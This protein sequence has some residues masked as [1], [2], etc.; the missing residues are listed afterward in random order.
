MAGA[1]RRRHER[2]RPDRRIGRRPAGDHLRR[3][4]PCRSRWP[5]RPARSG[6]R[7]VLFALRG[8]ADPA[9]RRAP[10]RITG[11]RSA[12]SAAFCRHA[13]AEGCRDVVF[14][15]SVVRPPSAR[16][17]LDLARCGCCRSSSRR[18]AAAT[19]IC[20]RASRKHVRAAGLPPARRARGGAGN[21]DAA[22]RSVGSRRPSEATGR[23]RA[24]ACAAARHR[25]ASTSARRSSSPTTTCWRSRRRRAPT[26]CWSG[27]PS[28]A[29]R[30]ASTPGRCGVLV[31]APKP[32]Q[33]RRFDLPS[34]GP[35]TVEGAAPRGPRRH[36]GRRPA[37]PSSRSRTA[38][39]R[40]PTAPTYSSSASAPMSRPHDT[41][42]GPSAKP[43]PKIFLV[44]GRGIRRPAGRRA[45]A[46]A[47]AARWGRASILRRRRPRDGGRRA[48][49]PAFRLDDF[50][51]IGFSAIPR[52][53]P[54]ILIGTCAQTLRA[55]RERG[56]A[57]VAG[58]H[59]Q[60]GLHAR[61]ARCVR[62]PI[63]D[64]PI[65]DYVSPSV[66]AWRPGARASRCA[67][68]IDQ[69][70]RCCRSSP[71]CIAS[72]AGRRAA[73]SAIRSSSRSGSFGPTPTRRG[74]AGR[75]AG[76]AG[77]AG[78]PQ[79][80]DRE[81]GRDR[82]AKRSAGSASGS[83]RSRWWCRPCRICSI[84][85]PRRP[86]PGRSSRASSP[87]RPRSRRRSASRAR[88]SPSRHGH[89]GAR[90]RRRADG[91]GLQ[92]VGARSHR[93][94]PRDHACRRH[95][96][97]SGDRRERRAR[98]AAGGLHAGKACRRTRRCAWATRPERRRQIEAFAWLDA[99]MEIGARAPPRRARPTSCSAKSTAPKQRGARRA[100]LC[101]RSSRIISAARSARSRGAARRYRAGAAG[102]CVWPG[103]SIISFHC[104]I[105]PTARATANST[106]N[107]VV[108]KP[109]ALSVMPE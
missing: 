26:R 34:I 32:D 59:R 35:R 37:A 79:R 92:G 43:L 68:Y 23:Y 25:A 36:R 109:I 52:R 93:H 46:R 51:I 106:V 15:G 38:S 65:I 99:I 74:G 30:G 6:R 105:Q 13:R 20:C 107:I 9:A 67:R 17:R 40:R 21:P 69:C 88:R 12:S 33:D 97:Q 53:L 77:A 72:S 63:A 49:Q 1:K 2:R 76:R 18:F 64:I 60:P 94:A 89:A 102:R 98:T 31:K 83:A 56:Q 103:S 47:A 87:S 5:T 19:I 66:W 27:W 4:Q 78:Q 91:R 75:S 90:A 10:I 22:G 48:R 44:A 84:A 3:R 42:T 104:A 96:G 24:R 95:P 54:T 82:S 71:A 50:S 7:V 86:H 16:L 28:C 73:M 41:R 85:S 11:S 70:W 101:R 14:I 62:A 108:G 39:R 55:V 45:D 58:H 81:A 29:A 8:W 61:V 100:P 57:D 80:R